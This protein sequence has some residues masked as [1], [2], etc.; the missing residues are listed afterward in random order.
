VTAKIWLGN[1]LVALAFGGLLF[2]SALRDVDLDF[3]LNA[4]AIAGVMIAATGV[5]VL[6]RNLAMTGRKQRAAH[7]AASIAADPR[8]P[9]VYLRSFADD[10]LLQDA[11]VVR[12]FIQ[13]TTEEE[14]LTSTGPGTKDQEQTTLQGQKT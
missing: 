14:Q 7:A 12:G 9:V 3:P 11:H 13:L 6:G 4:L 5:G 2:A 1:L 10:Q 8:P